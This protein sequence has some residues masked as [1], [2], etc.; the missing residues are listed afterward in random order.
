MAKKKKS[1]WDQIQD[2]LQAKVQGYSSLRPALC[3]LRSHNIIF[4]RNDGE[5]VKVETVMWC[6]YITCITAGGSRGWI[7]YKSC[8]DD[9]L[10]ILLSHIN[11]CISNE[12]NK[13]GYYFGKFIR[14]INPWWFCFNDSNKQL[15]S[16]LKESYEHYINKVKPTSERS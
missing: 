11:I 12:E 8:S 1:L 2:K 14:A 3:D 13:I 9:E 7:H 10:K 5:K 6:D 16:V 4:T 15:D